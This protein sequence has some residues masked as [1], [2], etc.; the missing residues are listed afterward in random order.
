MFGL[1]ILLEYWNQI[2]YQKCDW[3]IFFKYFLIMHIASVYNFVPTYYLFS[4]DNPRRV[5]GQT[6]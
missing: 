5:I 2:V 1:A 3:N 6:N 4:S